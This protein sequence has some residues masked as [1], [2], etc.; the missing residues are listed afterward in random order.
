MEQLFNF[1][2]KKIPSTSDNEFLDRKKCLDLFL[3]KGFPNKKDENWKFTDLNYIISKNFKNITNNFNFSLDKKIELINDF[4]HNY[5]FTINGSYK[6]CDIRFEDKTKVKIENL[7]LSDGFDYQSSNSL[8]NLNKAL[9]QGGF[10]LEIQD[11]YKCRKPIVIYNYFTS[12]LSNEIINNSN[13]IRLNQNSELTL[14][15]YNVGV[16]SKFIKNTF[17]KIDIDKGSILKS[18][19]IQKKKNNGYFY[20]NISGSQGYNSVFQNFILS[21]GLK[22]NRIEIDMNLKKENCNCYILSGLSLDNGEQQ[23]I[24][25]QINHLAPNC[26]SYQKIKNVLESDSKGVYQGKIF[27][28]DISQKN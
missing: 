11:N 20:K 24:K 18:I 8:V 3:E 9:S 17:E 7:K 27:V 25:T 26:K 10:N 6:S 12:N 13:K 21:S 22:F 4:E 2:L 15:E 1:D 5:I 28:K 14:I 19:N 23:E 16:N